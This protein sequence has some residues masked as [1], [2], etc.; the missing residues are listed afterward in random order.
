MNEPR[1]SFFE[2]Q[3]SRQAKSDDE[4]N[5]WL[6]GSAGQIA[7]IGL[8]IAFVVMFIIILIAEGI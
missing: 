5:E 2:R 4:V 6:N 3:A 7:L 1:K 8:G